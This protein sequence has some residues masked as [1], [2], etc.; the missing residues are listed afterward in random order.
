MPNAIQITRIVVAAILAFLTL[1]V[2]ARVDDHYTHGAPLLGPYEI[3][4]IYEDD[5]LG[6]RGKP[7]AS[8]LKWKLNS[9]GFRGPELAPGKLTVA[10]LGASETFGLY[11]TEGKEYPRQLEALLRERFGENV[12]VASI[13]FA[14]QSVGQALFRLDENIEAVDPALLVVYPSLAAY[15]NAP[16][17]EGEWRLG[18]QAP[19]PPFGGSRIAQRTRELLKQALPPAVQTAMRAWQ[20]ERTYSKDEVWPRIPQEN[21]DRFRTDINAL[22]EQ[23]NAHGVEVALATHATLFGDSVEPDERLHLIDWRKFFPILAEDGFLDMERRL[24]DVL[25]ETGQQHGLVVIDV[26]NKIEPGA[27]NF[28]DFVHLNDKGAHEMASILAE[29]IAPVIAKHF[30]Q[31]P[32]SAAK[33][34]P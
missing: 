11:E 16:A 21:V 4:V 28:V 20:S 7:N 6:R 33:P 24:N 23:A 8:Y 1:E 29:G 2:S 10:V 17:G 31:E 25:R 3:S 32:D 27:G 18:R 34:L 30:H 15:I 9:L 26:A 12:Q 22:I 19:R 14:G 13:G 5:E